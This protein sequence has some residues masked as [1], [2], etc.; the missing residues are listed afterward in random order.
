MEQHLLVKML[1]VSLSVSGKQKI[2]T[3]EVMMQF[4]RWM[5]IFL[6]IKINQN[7]LCG[8]HGIEVLLLLLLLMLWGINLILMFV[9]FMF[10]NSNWGVGNIFASWLKK[11]LTINS[12]AVETFSKPE[13]FLKDIDFLPKNGIALLSSLSIDIGLSCLV[14]SQRQAAMNVLYWI[15]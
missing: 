13:I 9:V 6:I 1:M 8:M 3:A 5:E 4:A 11:S 7:I 12:S 14:T 2:A 10:Y 15:K